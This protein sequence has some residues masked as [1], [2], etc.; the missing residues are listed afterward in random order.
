MKVVVAHLSDIHFKSHHNQV[1][2]REGEIAS[3][4]ASCARLA[5]GCFIVVSG[6]VA[7][8]GRVDEYQVAAK[9]LKRIFEM[10]KRE[11]NG[12]SFNI[13]IVPGNHDCDFTV[14][15]AVRTLML[16]NGEQILEGLDKDDNSIVGVLTRVQDNFFSF[17]AELEMELQPG[18]NGETARALLLGYERL[19]YKREFTIKDQNFRFD[20]YNS[21]WTSQLHE[22]QAQLIFPVLGWGIDSAKAD[23]NISTFHHPTRW[24]ESN[25]A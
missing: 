17:L 1:H 19:H 13:I 15:N 7:F 9:F 22:K 4:I 11:I 8:S 24:L 18:R 3:A 10:L 16:N 25:N 2:G 14:Q 5:E 21:A 12:C 20:C 23:L 6:D